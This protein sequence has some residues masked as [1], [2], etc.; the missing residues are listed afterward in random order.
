VFTGCRAN[1]LGRERSDSA[2]AGRVFPD[3]APPLEELPEGSLA[4]VEHAPTGEV[5]WEN[6][7]GGAWVLFNKPVVPLARLPKPAA[8]SDAMRLQPALPGVFRWYG[9][10]LLA[11]EPEGA[12][13]P[14]TEYTV[15]IDPRLK[16]QDGST[17]AGMD[18][19]RFR[20]PALRLL[21]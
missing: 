11:F 14:A 4:V 5:P 6:L 3:D 12:P 8:S 21:S 17:L 10:R 18:A 7:E 1:L 9:S 2:R 16:A 15:L 13:A 20:T 19:F